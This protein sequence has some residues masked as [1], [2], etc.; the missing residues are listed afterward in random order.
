MNPSGQIQHRM[1]KFSIEWGRLAARE[2]PN[3][4]NSVLEMPLHPAIYHGM[5]P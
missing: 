2:E 4:A 1:A 3:P 5:M